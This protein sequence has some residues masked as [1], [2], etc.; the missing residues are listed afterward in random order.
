MK[1]ILLGSSSPLCSTQLQNEDASHEHHAWHDEEDE[2]NQEVFPGLKVVK[3]DEA[4]TLLVKLT[5][6]SDKKYFWHTKKYT[7][8]PLWN[9]WY[10]Q[11][12]KAVAAIFSVWSKSI[13]KNQFGVSDCEYEEGLY[14][15]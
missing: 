9:R 8:K 1:E 12:K 3:S 6:G 14:M 15:F 13:I 7:T 4:S 2:D 11:T 10:S 5:F